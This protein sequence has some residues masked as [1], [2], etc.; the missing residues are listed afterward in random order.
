MSFFVYQYERIRSFSWTYSFLF[1]QKKIHEKFEFI[2]SVTGYVNVE[3]YN[4]YKV[5]EMGGI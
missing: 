1:S 5:K 2:F 3:F 4:V